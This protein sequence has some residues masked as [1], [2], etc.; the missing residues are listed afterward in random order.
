MALRKTIK[1]CLLNVSVL[2][3]IIIRLL[4][5]HFFNLT[6]YEY[7]VCEREFTVELFKTHIGGLYRAD[8]CC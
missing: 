2:V 5:I 4:F 7:I 3:I 1:L 8:D 6:E